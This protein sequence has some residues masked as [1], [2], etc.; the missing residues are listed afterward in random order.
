MRPHNQITFDRHF[1]GGYRFEISELLD[2]ASRGF[3]HSLKCHHF[4]MAGSMVAVCR[5]HRTLDLFIVT[6]H[7]GFEPHEI[8]DSMV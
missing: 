3:E 5:G 7:E 4:G 2:R 6:E 8:R 1:N